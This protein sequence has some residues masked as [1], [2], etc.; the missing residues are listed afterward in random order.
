MH[1]YSE[2]VKIQKGKR[3]SELHKQSKIVGKAA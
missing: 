3:Q 1:V 2:T